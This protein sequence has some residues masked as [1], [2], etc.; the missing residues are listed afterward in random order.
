MAYSM[1]T[2]QSDARLARQTQ[3]A[4]SRDP[5]LCG[6][7]AFMTG[8]VWGMGLAETRGLAAEGAGG[9]TDLRVGMAAAEVRAMTGVAADPFTW[10]R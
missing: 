8:G 3:K 2:C 5:T 10:T 4:G 6:Q 1:R 9:T 7:V